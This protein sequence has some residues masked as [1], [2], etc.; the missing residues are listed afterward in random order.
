MAQRV[1]RVSAKAKRIYIARLLLSTTGSTLTNDGKDAGL[2][3]GARQRG[4][5]KVGQNTPG[6]LGY[7]DCDH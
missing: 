3:R 6:A 2:P 7:Y 4:E 5:R 1:C